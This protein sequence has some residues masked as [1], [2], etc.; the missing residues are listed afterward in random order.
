MLTNRRG[1]VTDYLLAL[2][3]SSSLVLVGLVSDFWKQLS[4]YERRVLGHDCITMLST[5]CAQGVDKLW[6]SGAGCAHV[7]HRQ[8]AD[9]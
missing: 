2:L 4:S 1:G 7:I 5:C 6:I 8:H 3:L 9:S